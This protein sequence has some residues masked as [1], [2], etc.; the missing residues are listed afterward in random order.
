MTKKKE[1]NT[2]VPV[3]TKEQ[4][5]QSKVFTNAEKDFLDAF[6]DESTTYTLDEAKEIYK[7]KIKGVVK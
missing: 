1:V 7:K 3:F 5:L 2:T 6:L 4:L